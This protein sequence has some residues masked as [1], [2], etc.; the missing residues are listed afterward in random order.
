M[1]YS[2]ATGRFLELSAER[3]LFP[4][5]VDGLLD[6]ELRP[7]SAV[8]QERRRGWAAHLAAI[9]DDDVDLGL[10]AGALRGVLDSSDYLHAVDDLAEDDV[11]AVKP[12]GHDS[13]DEKLRACRAISI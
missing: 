1:H 9:C 10:V 6:L 5:R 8:A 3:H 12:R 7:M 2:L 4:V 11:A 13:C